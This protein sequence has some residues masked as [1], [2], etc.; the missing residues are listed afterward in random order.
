ML[1]SS[2]L[3]CARLSSLLY[4]LRAEA[5]VTS[6]DWPSEKLAVATKA[7]LKPTGTVALAGVSCSSVT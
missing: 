7:W 2:L 6:R 5:L 4:Q 3:T 1:P